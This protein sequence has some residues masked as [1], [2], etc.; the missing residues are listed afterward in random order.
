MDVAPREERAR[1]ETS[2]PEVPVVA[3]EQTERAAAV[4][5]GPILSAVLRPLDWLNLD[6]QNLP[7]AMPELR[8]ADRVKEIP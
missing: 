8:S 1:E 7:V 6:L 5:A 2:S 3:V 4:A